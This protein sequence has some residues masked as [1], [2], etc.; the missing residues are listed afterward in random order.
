[1]NN[2]VTRFPVGFRTSKPSPKPLAYYPI[3]P[4]PAI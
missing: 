2:I 4:I 3:L 1:M